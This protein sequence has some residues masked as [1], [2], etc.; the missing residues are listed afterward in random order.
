MRAQGLMLVSLLGIGCATV[1]SGNVQ[2]VELR[3][4]PSGARAVIRSNDGLVQEVTTPAKVLLRTGPTHVVTV[5]APGHRPTTAVIGKT[6]NWWALLGGPLAM[7]DWVSGAIY[8]LDPGVLELHMPPVP[9]G[10]GDAPCGCPHDQTPCPHH[11]GGDRGE[12]PP[13]KE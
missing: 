10:S 6:I 7:Y 12:L 13:A 3:S 5:L 8:D 2:E 9:P 4:Q 11:H 1:I